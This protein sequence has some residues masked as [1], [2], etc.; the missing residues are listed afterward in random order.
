[1]PIRVALFNDTAVNGHFGCM[2]VMSTIFSQ[3]AAQNFEFVMVWPAG[4]DWRCHK[5]E[6]K[7]RDIDLVV[8]NGEGSIHHTDRNERA[9]ALC[10]IGRFANDELSVPAVLINATLY[11]I[12][13]TG[14][15]LLRHF[16]R[17]FVRESSSQKYLEQNDVQSEWLPDLSLFSPHLMLRDTRRK[18]FFVTDSVKRDVSNVLQDY[19]LKNGVEFVE[20]VEPR[21]RSLVERALS[22]LRGKRE[23]NLQEP[24]DVMAR[25]Y[26]RLNAFFDH[27]GHSEL[28][29]S[30]RFHSCMLCIAARTPV[31][32][33]ESNTPKISYVFRDIFGD[34][35][36]IF[37]TESLTTKREDELIQYA[38]FDKLDMKN[39]EMYV[40]NGRKSMHKMFKD[41]SWLVGS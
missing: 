16:S 6:I 26:G 13:D 39:I 14:F 28:V 38:S 2:A 17:I 8:V 27:I 4:K 29:V 25:R 19:A 31:I 3:G 9:K 33:I 12:D 11:A 7:A 30:G 22:K 40:N 35:K 34:T 23:I 15:E 20:M 37:T 32:A 36:R 41:I 5:E 24:R 1:M 21:R 18:G 10:S